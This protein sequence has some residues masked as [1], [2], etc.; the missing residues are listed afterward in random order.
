MTCRLRDGIRVM[1][2]VDDRPGVRLDPALE[3]EPLPVVL[4]PDGG[5]LRE[6]RRQAVDLSAHTKEKRR[7]EET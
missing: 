1:K 6:G 2:P 3:Q 4:L 7:L 5:L